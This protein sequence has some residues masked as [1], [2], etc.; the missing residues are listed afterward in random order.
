MALEPEKKDISYQYGRLLAVLEKVEKD[1]Y[2]STEK[3]ETNAIRMQAAFVQR[4]QSTQVEIYERLR[5]AYF[6]KLKTANQQ[7]RYHMLIG[8]IM[9]QISQ[10][11]D[12]EQ[13]QPL[14]DTYLMGY[15]LQ[16]NELYKSKEALQEEEV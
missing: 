15:Y 9:E 12:R 16:R 4:P 8:E 5:N 13:K 1:T 11:S 10:F 6:P 2:E 14:K 7:R 3:R